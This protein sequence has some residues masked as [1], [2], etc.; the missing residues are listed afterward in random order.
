MCAVFGIVWGGFFGVC[1]CCVWDSF[2]RVCGR[3]FLLCGGGGILGLAW[4]MESVLC[5]G[6]FVAF[7]GE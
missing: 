2:G 7:F 1:L 6:E 5:V 4:Q 3:D